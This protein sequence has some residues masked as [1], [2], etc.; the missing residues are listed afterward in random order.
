MPPYA[1]LSPFLILFYLPLFYLVGKTVYRA[2][3]LLRKNAVAAR[4]ASLVILVS[5]L[6]Y[7]FVIEL[8]FTLIYPTAPHF[9]QSLK[10]WIVGG[11]IPTIVTF[12]IGGVNHPKPEENTTENEDFSK[13][14]NTNTTKD[15]LE[16][17]KNNT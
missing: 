2:A 10:F 5:S 1:A 16:T 15:N 13:P 11:L 9:E 17:T 4:L 3:Y 6:F 12:C 14:E 8:A 7:L